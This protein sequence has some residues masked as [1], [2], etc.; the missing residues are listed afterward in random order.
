MPNMNGKALPKSPG[1]CNDESIYSFPGSSNS[2]SGVEA[3]ILEILSHIHIQ[4][5]HGPNNCQCIKYR[6]KTSLNLERYGIANATHASLSIEGKSFE[7][8]DQTASAH[9]DVSQNKMKVSTK[10]NLNFHKDLPLKKKRAQIENS[11]RERPLVDAPQD[12]LILPIT[13]KEQNN[14]T[15]QVVENPVAFCSVVPLEMP[16]PMSV[17]NPKPVLRRSY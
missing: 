11:L 7:Y 4:G 14:C 9:L 1:S 17:R 10:R 8:Q 5:C 16:V 6:S 12:L 2:C 15:T 13:E 3:I